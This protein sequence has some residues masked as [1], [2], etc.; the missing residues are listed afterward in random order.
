MRHQQ[1]QQQTGYRMYPHGGAGGGMP[2]SLGRPDNGNGY[3]RGASSASP[4]NYMIMAD[5]GYGNSQG[6]PAYG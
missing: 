3:D 5:T 6:H 1:Y 4:E 2:H